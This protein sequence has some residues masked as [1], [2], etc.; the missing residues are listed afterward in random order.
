MDFGKQVGRTNGNNRSQTFEPARGRKRPAEDRLNLTIDLAKTINKEVGGS[1]KGR[2]IT[3]A[4]S[5]PAR[6]KPGTSQRKLTRL[7]RSILDNTGSDQPVPIHGGRK[8]PCLELDLTLKTAPPPLM[9]E[10]SLPPEDEMKVDEVDLVIKLV[11]LKAPSLS[12]QHYFIR[13]KIHQ[14]APELPWKELGDLKPHGRIIAEFLNSELED[15]RIRMKVSEEHIE[16]WE[17][18]SSLLQKHDEKGLTKIM[19]RILPDLQAKGYFRGENPSPWDILW[20]LETNIQA[21]DSIV[22]LLFNGLELTAFPHCCKNLCFPFVEYISCADNQFDLFPKLLLDLAPG[23]RTIIFRNNRIK[24]YPTLIFYH[25]NSLSRLDLARNSIAEM[26]Y[27]LLPDTEVR[28]G[29]YLNVDLTYNLID[30]LQ[31]ERFKIHRQR[32]EILLC[33]NLIKLEDLPDVQQIGGLIIRMR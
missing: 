18:A 20:M 8:K 26:P 33:G 10:P 31:S 6:S 28:N 11:P 23:A 30:S 7:Q 29:K 21:A 25:L 16:S 9:Q 3:R 5:Q 13:A 2:T 24:K 19:D 14:I 12:Q 32:I 15:R 1:L 4:L 17:A 22:K 27:D